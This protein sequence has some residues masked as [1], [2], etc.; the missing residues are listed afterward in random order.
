LEVNILKNPRQASFFLIGNIKN[1]FDKVT[2]E[3]IVSSTWN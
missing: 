2:T 1:L 3:A